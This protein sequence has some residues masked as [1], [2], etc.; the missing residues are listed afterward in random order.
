MADRV[1]AL[2]QIVVLQQLVFLC[3]CW[4]YLLHGILGLK[5]LW[6]IAENGVH[7]CVHVC[8]C[9]CVWVCACVYVY[10][11]VYVCAC[12]AVMCTQMQCTVCITFHS[13]LHADNYQCSINKVL[14]CLIH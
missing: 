8:V 5:M 7:V 10:V 9:V 14:H 4:Y 3:H 12:V 6:P 1:I 11:C 13:F 2:W